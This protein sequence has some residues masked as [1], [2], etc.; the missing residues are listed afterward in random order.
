MVRGFKSPDKIKLAVVVGGHPYDVPGFRG[1]F[2]RM[3]GVDYFIQE[4]DTWSV[5]QW[6]GE[7]WDQYDVH[8]F[9]TMSGYGRGAA[10]LS[11]RDDYDD[12]IAASVQRLGEKAQGILVLHHAV[13][14]F[15]DW[16]PEVNQT[17]DKI[18]NVG[19]R[20]LKEFHPGTEH[21]THV[22]DASH[23]ITRGMKDWTRQDETFVLEQ[24]PG[25]ESQVLLSVDNPLS[26]KALGWVH[27]YRNS[28]VF[29][30]QAGHDNRAYVDP[31]FQTILLRGIQWLAGRI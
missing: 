9:Y 29:C 4:L 14:N 7:V 3:P 8:L 21:V 19:D 31:S 22:A 5:D 13:L 18:C 15:C 24:E 25:P 16:R 12:S 6:A 2:D 23:P 26:M 28:R 10:I 11:V 27:E 30:L 17:W 20:H 1:L